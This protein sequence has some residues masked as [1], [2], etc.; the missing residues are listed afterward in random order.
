MSIVPNK[1]TFG[2]N[3]TFSLRYSWIPKGIGACLKNHKVFSEDSAPLELGVG[4]NMVK[5]IKYWLEAYQVIKEDGTLTAF[6]QQVFHPETGLDPFLEDDIAV[7]MAVSPN[8]DIFD[9]KS[10]IL[11]QTT[12]DVKLELSVNISSTILL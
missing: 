8:S 6:G 2:R 3:E 10:L 4:K 5:S 9:S 1:F 11:Q 12:L 7:T